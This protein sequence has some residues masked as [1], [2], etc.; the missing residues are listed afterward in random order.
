MK[1]S[2][3][4]SRRGGVWSPAAFGRPDARRPR[5]GTCRPAC[6][7]TAA[8]RLLAQQDQQ[9]DV[10]AVVEVGGHDGGG[11]HAESP[12][13]QSE[14]CRASRVDVGE[15]RPVPLLRSSRHREPAVTRSR[16]PSWSTST[17]DAAAAEEPGR[18]PRRRGDVLE[19]CRPPRWCS[20]ASLPA[21]RRTGPDGRRCRSRRRVAAV[22]AAFAGGPAD[23]PGR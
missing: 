14:T 17:H 18:N 7:G 13:A 12:G 15:R 21:Q 20:R 8:A 10:A 1:P 5:P 6:S 23:R 3:L 9:V 2:L 22:A 4:T 19:R 11:P 16:S